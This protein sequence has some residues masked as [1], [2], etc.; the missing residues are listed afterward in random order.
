[1]LWAWGSEGW[2]FGECF[3]VRVWLPQA[4]NIFVFPVAGRVPVGDCLEFRDAI[5][6]WELKE[7]MPLPVRVPSPHFSY[8][9]QQN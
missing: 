6:P 3:E 4:L 2:G 5:E 8:G 9:R 7:V 1:M